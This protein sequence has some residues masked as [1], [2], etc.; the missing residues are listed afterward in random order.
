VLDVETEVIEQV[1]ENQTHRHSQHQEETRRIYPTS[2]PRPD[3]IEKK[4]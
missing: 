1:R 4:E 3:H 2:P